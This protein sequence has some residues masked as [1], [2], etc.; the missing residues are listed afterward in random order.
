M[1]RTEHD[2]MIE[3][4]AAQGADEAFDIG[5]LPRRPRR[6]L[7]FEYPQRLDSAGEHGAVDRIAVAQQVAR[8][9]VPGE[10]LH[11]LLSRPLGRRDV[12]DVDVDDASPVMRQDDED[13]NTLNSTVG[14]VKKST[15]T[16]LRMWLSR[17]E[18]QVCEGGFR[19]RTTYLD[20]VA[21]EISRP[22]F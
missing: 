18:C 10:R 3:A 4:L 19:W 5:V 12:G 16:R 6:R 13:N 15:E 14:T 22:S 1:G 9:G 2:H 8:G 17:N 11:E 20:T 21:W 7:D